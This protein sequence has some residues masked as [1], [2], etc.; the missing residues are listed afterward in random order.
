MSFSMDDIM[1]PATAQ[2]PASAYLYQP[3]AMPAAAAPPPAAHA[4]NGE[5]LLASD[6]AVQL[7]LPQPNGA[8]GQGEEAGPPRLLPPPRL[9]P[10]PKPP[11]SAAE[12]AA[13]R[14]EAFFELLRHEGVRT[15]RCQP[16]RSSGAGPCPQRP[17]GG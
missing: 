2:P 7:V 4:S 11:P 13:E 1:G 3:A 8:A 9:A 10:L 5:P 17:A 16:C 12:Q 14:R 6:D 15:S